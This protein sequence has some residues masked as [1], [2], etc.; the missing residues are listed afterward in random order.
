MSEIVNLFIDKKSQTKLDGV[1]GVFELRAYATDGSSGSA[2]T[3]GKIIEVSDLLGYYSFKS[4]RERDD[5]GTAY[6]DVSEI[7]S[8]SILIK[9]YKYFSIYYSIGLEMILKTDKVEIDVKGESIVYAPSVTRVLFDSKVVNFSFN[10]RSELQMSKITSDPIGLEKS[11][12]LL[13]ENLRLNYIEKQR[14]YEAIK[15]EYEEKLKSTNDI[16][17]NQKEIYYPQNFTFVVTRLLE[18]QE[19]TIEPGIEFT[20]DA[21]LELQENILRDINRLINRLSELYPDVSIKD[22]EGQPYTG[23]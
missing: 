4:N 7:L 12:Q 23:K 20:M 1:T 22:G 9:F 14:E 21:K 2:G 10:E 17:L 11:G 18:L 3:S 15:R 8:N 6:V 13:Y 19:G 16:I 5:P